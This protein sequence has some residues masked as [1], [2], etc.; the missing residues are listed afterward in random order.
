MSTS[1]CEKQNSREIT[2]TTSW[3][4][5][6][7]CNITALARNSLIPVRSC[8]FRRTSPVAFSRSLHS[9]VHRFEIPSPQLCLALPLKWWLSYLFSNEFSTPS[10]FYLFIS[11]VSCVSAAKQI[12]IGVVWGRAWHLR[13]F[14]LSCSQPVFGLNC[15]SSPLWSEKNTIQ[16]EA[17]PLEAISLTTP[18]PSLHALRGYLSLVLW[19]EYYIYWETYLQGGKLRNDSSGLYC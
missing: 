19:P 14:I 1:K 2:S 7:L 3:E 8:L 9:S 12:F 17:E 6:K 16:F 11:S 4:G 13:H 5:N 10:V 18:F 15:L